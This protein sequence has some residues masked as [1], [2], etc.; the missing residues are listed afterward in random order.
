MVQAAKDRP[1]PWLNER[2]DEFKPMIDELIGKGVRVDV[3]YFIDCKRPTVW[4]EGDE[5]EGFRVY[6][7]TRECGFHVMALRREWHYHS[8]L[9]GLDDPMWMI[10]FVLSWSPSYRATSPAPPEFAV[11]S[12]DT[13][14][15]T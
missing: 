8:Y 13:P 4:F 3:A 11:E 14:T 9:N 5:E 15:L 2:W 10:E 1:K 12:G 7:I 6:Q